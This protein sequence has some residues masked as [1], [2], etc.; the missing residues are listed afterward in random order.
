MVSIIILSYNTKTLLRACLASIYTHTKDVESEI[1]VVDNAS[2]DES[3]SMVK[4]EFKRVMLIENKEN[5]G[6]AKG[7]NQAAKKAHGEYLLFLNSDTEMHKETFKNALRQFEQN[8][9][10]AILG[11]FLDNSDGTTSRSYGKFLS[12][13]STFMLLFGDRTVRSNQLQKKQSVDWVSGGCMFVRRNIFEEVKGFDEQF[14]MYIEDM[15]LCYR[16]NQRGY[17]IM[18]YPE[19]SVIHKA[20]GSSN[21]SFAIIEIYK[22]LIYFYKKH[23]TFFSY[24]ILRL[25]LYSKAYSAIVVGQVTRNNNLVQTYKKAKRVI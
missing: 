14:F 23:K 6:F 20:Q 5:V 3:V 2:H 24:Q 11:G 22:G 13:Y 8:E 19:F 7:C 21:R 4:K 10:L 16:I 15:E 25:M 9:K 17:A 12:L 18:Y 1:I